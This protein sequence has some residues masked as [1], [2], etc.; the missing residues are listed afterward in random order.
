MGT[1]TRRWDGLAGAMAA[2]ALALSACGGSDSNDASPD[3]P[4]PPPEQPAPLSTP[5]PKFSYT[6]DPEVCTWMAA[7]VEPF[8]WP[9]D[10]VGPRNW[11]EVAPVVTYAHPERNEQGL[12]IYTLTSNNWVLTERYGPQARALGML[13]PVW[14]LWAQQVACDHGLVVEPVYDHALRAAMSDETAAR[15][16]R[17]AY[18]AK[19]SQTDRCA[20]GFTFTGLPPRELPPECDAPAQ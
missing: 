15:I 10:R 16:A 20:A 19:L 3:N 12:P 13:E 17:E 14:R 2:I 7:H 11:P 4:T 8:Q 6:P 1:T 18:A 9:A 5:A